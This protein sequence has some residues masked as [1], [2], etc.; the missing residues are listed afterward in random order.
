MKI[1]P[2]QF[3]QYDLA[4]QAAKDKDYGSS[5]DV[6]INKYGYVT[7][8]IRI[9]DKLS[10]LQRLLCNKAQVNTESKLDTW[11]DLANYAIMAC[12]H[13]HKEFAPKHKLASF[14]YGLRS[15]LIYKGIST[16][17]TEADCVE[18][19]QEY[20]DTM[21]TMFK[22]SFKQNPDIPLSVAMKQVKDATLSIAS[23]AICNVLMYDDSNLFKS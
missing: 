15:A 18:M 3:L 14:D 7:A 19:C 6:T 1:K 2:E 20:N 4:L 21:N 9:H 10:R 13:M 8:C 16:D 17:V 5:F 22:E 11:I 12:N 23:I